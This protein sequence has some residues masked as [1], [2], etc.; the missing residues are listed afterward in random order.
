MKPISRRLWAAALLAL[1]ILACPAGTT[2]AQP[3]PGQGADAARVGEDNLDDM[4][5]KFGPEAQALKSKIEAAIEKGAAWLLGKQLPDGHFPCYDQ[6]GFG[7]PLGGT[8]LCVLALKKSMV[9]L[10]D[11]DEKDLDK[12]TRALQAKKA[13]NKID[14]KESKRLEYLEKEAPA[15]LAL[16]KKLQTAADKGIDWLRKNYGAIKSGPQS[17]LPG[18]GTSAPFRTYDL[19]ILLMVLEAYY[20]EK[21]K[22]ADGYVMDVNQKK[23]PKGD[24]EWIREMTDWLGSRVVTPN[25]GGTES[26]GKAWRYPGEAGDGSSVDASNTQYAV[27]GLK[28]ASRMGV[29]IKDPNMWKQVCEYFISVQEADGPTVNR[30]PPQVKPTGEYVFAGGPEGEADKARGWSYLPKVDAHHPPTGAMTTAALAALITA[31]SALYEAKVL[32]ANKDLESKIDRAINDGLAWLTN[33]YSIEQNPSSNKGMNV[34]WHYYYLY[35]L[36]RAGVLAQQEFFGKN[37]WYIDGAK[38]LTSKQAAEGYWDSNSAAAHPAAGTE[39][40]RICDTCFALLFLKRATVPVKV[41][42]TVPKPVVTGD[43]K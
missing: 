18:G 6:G 27:L 10:Y 26:P 2:F 24:L 22:V 4:L 39:G 20:T 13:Q 7:Y 16:R 43:G 11:G 41:P 35:G 19:G 29:Q 28:S 31:K 8:A 5:R 34:G 37:A 21:K 3:K 1:A 12:E 38:L 25:F 30:K 40:N 36:E 9:G 14:Y 15:E 17:P 33:F 42:L 23:I 32:P